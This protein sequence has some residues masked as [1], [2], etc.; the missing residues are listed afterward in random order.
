MPVSVVVADACVS[1]TVAPVSRVTV[2]EAGVVTASL[3][4]AVILI[5]WEALYEPF[6]VVEENDDTVGAVVSTT[7]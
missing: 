5:V 1:T 6:V 3:N 2:M 7:V 4:V